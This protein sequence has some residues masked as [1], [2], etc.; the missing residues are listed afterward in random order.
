M[1]TFPIRTFGDPGLK[2]PIAPVRESEWGSLRRLADEMIATM[3]DA[4]GVGLAANQIGVQKRM[5]VYDI[6]DG[7]RVVVNPSIVETEGEWV[8]DEGCL[9]V[10]DLFFAITRPNAVHLTAWDLE[11]EAIDAWG[12]ELLG[13]V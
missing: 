4:P 11:G 7:P 10:P 3:Y 8:Y 9:S 2:R 5:F 13:R 12:A 6:G 1:A